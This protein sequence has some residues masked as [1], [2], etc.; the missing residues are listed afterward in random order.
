MTFAKDLP[1]K[2]LCVLSVP[3]KRQK[4]HQ[5]SAY[6]AEFLVSHGPYMTPP[7]LVYRDNYLTKGIYFL[8]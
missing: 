4:C 1:D 3:K 8:F 7:L 6:F 2:E 5:F